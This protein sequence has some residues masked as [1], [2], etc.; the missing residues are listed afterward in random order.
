MKVLV[1][2]SNCRYVVEGE[3][4]LEVVREVGCTAISLTVI[5]D[6]DFNLDEALEKV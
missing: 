5:H 6:C 1:I 3:T 2:D 4:W